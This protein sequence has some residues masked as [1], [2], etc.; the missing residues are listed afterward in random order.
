MNKKMLK[1]ILLKNWLKGQNSYNL[2]DS[3]GQ[4][5]LCSE[6]VLKAKRSL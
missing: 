4:T 6:V 3:G 2:A 1:R 5:Q